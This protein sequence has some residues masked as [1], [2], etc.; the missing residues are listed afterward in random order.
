MA[1]ETKRILIT[2]RTYPTPAR[3]SVETSCT[4]GITSDGKWIRLFP[5]PYRDLKP[6][7]KFSKYQWIEARIQKAKNDP[8]PESFN[9]D[10]DSIRPISGVLSTE[11]EWQARKDLVFPLR[12]HCL[13]CLKQER[14]QRGAPTLGLF[15]PAKIRRLLIEKDEPDWTEDQNAILRQGSLF[16]TEPKEALE[17]I[18]FKFSYEFQCAESDCTGHKAIC[19]DWE[20]GESYRK[21]RQQYGDKWEAAFRQ[22]YEQ[23]MIGK[24][25]TH[26]YVGTLH[27]YPGTW[28]IVGLF[29]PQVQRQASLFGS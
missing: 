3:K 21:W 26:L 5:M 20:M 1:W 16:E 4:G 10:R 8:R 12:A 14:D 6:G 18:P 19:T 13:C 29:Y 9:P 11:N 15:K 24:L 23:E 17:K 28:I 25:D 27:Q 2:V 22:R 7:Q